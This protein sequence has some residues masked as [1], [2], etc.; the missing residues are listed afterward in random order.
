MKIDFHA[1]CLPPSYYEFL[2]I[3]GMERPD[4]FPT[5]EWSVDFQLQAMKELDIS[6]AFLSISSPPVSCDD[7][8]LTA[9]YVRKI[10]EEMAKIVQ[11]YPNKLGFFA[12]LPLPY[13]DE[14]LAEIEYC[15]DTLKCDGF[16]LAT[17]YNGDH[18]GSPKFVSV[19]ESF[20]K[21][22][23]LLCIH[24]T[25]PLEVSADINSDVFPI[26]A[27]EFFFETTRTVAYLI[28]QDT[29]RKYSDIKWIIPHAGACVSTFSD[30][31]AVF[32]GMIRAKGNPNCDFLRDIRNLYYDVAGMS[33]PKLLHDLLLDVP[34]SHLLYGSDGPY[35]SLDLMKKL[36]NDL[37][38]ASAL[39]ADVREKVYHEN[40]FEIVPRLKE[41]FK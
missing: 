19:Y 7:R 33:A 14:T 16:G 41:I 13:I 22:K 17:N 11:Q 39:S 20:Q 36:A 35:T 37:D 27:M 28:I 34:A 9:K 30:R 2:K 21:H 12:I 23:S 4:G 18:L 25:A 38:N 29:I 31:W 8:D 26:P 40:A 5:P 24:P 3:Q 10:N 1:H 32:N 6:F 15:I